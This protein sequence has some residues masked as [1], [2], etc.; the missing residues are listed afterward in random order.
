M[1]FVVIGGGAA[2]VAAIEKLRSIDA[3]A[4]IIL[5]ESEKEPFYLRPALTEYLAGT[6]ERGKL[7]VKGPDLADRLQVK[8]ISGVLER[9]LFKDKAIL[10]K[11]GITIN[12]DKLLLATG[13]SPIFL[14]WPGN[15][16]KGVY[17]LRTLEDA[18][19]IIADCGPGKRAIVVGGG[20]LGMELSEALTKRGMK[21]SLLVRGDKFGYPLVDEGTG[22]YLKD[23]FI[24]NGVEVI[25]DD[26]VAE[27][28]GKE[29]RLEGIITLKG[30]RYET[31]I[32]ALAVGVKANTG[33]CSS[34]ELSIG[35]GIRVNQRMETSVPDVYAAGD[36]VEFF[37]SDTEEYKMR[38][39]WAHAAKMGQIAAINMTGGQAEYKEMAWSSTK[40]FGLPLNTIGD[41]VP[42]QGK[43]SEVVEYAPEPGKYYRGLIVNGT[44]AGAI[45]LGDRLKVNKIK[46]LVENKSDISEDKDTLFT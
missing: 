10:L 16:L 8:M 13:A 21:V 35:R 23:H 17:G 25:M 41:L 28:Y 29:S 31:D 32:L 37:D 24:Q 3:S 34:E 46:A 15:D 4:E 5:V 40:L 9:V 38:G 27:A 36:V 26:E 20:V 33:A 7:F 2:G 18:E 19:A 45:M 39:F 30:Q 11:N 42:P 12:Y 43:P 6:M 22:S 14:P 44:L 1:K